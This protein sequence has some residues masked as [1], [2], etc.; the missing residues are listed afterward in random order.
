VYYSKRNFSIFKNLTSKVFYAS[1]K[2]WEAQVVYMKSIIQNFTSKVLYTSIKLLESL[3][4]SYEVNFEQMK[5]KDEFYQKYDFVPI[6]C[7]SK[8]LWGLKM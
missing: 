7:M 6:K 8:K 1:I 4:S 2:L 3:S 5:I